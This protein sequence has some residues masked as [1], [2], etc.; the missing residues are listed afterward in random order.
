MEK[1]IQ[2]TRHGKPKDKITVYLNRVEFCTNRAGIGVKI[3]YVRLFDREAFEVSK[4]HAYG[5]PVT[6][7]ERKN[8]KI[9]FRYVVN[10]RL[11]LSQ[12]GR[13]KQ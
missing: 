3:P 9:L 12:T 5:A 1:I 2:S 11:K 7:L 10:F 13:A 4:S 6:F 8:H